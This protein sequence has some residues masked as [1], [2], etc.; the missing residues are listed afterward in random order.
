MAAGALTGNNF[1]TLKCAKN[2]L[3]ELVV[4]TLKCGIMAR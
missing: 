3:S 1:Y 2:D 4:E